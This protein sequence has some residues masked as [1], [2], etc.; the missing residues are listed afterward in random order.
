MWKSRELMALS[1]YITHPNVQT[2][3]AVPVPERRLNDEGRRRATTM[4][5]HPWVRSVRTIIGS[6]ETKALE[7][8][9][10]LGSH[11]GVEVDVDLR[12]GR[13]TEAPPV[14]Y[15]RGVMRSSQIDSSPNPFALWRVG[16]PPSTHRPGSCTQLRNCSHTIGETSQS[17]GTVLSERC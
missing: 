1:R 10:L 13:R 4:V 17:S 16:K 11:L 3:P 8:A 5:V 2:D 15:R 12:S 9:A 14:S 7:T 6:S